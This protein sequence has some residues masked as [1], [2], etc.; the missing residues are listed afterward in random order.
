MSN[1][2][3]ADTRFVGQGQPDSITVNVHEEPLAALRY[4]E[5]P[6]NM[7]MKIDYVARTDSNPVYIGYVGRGIAEDAG[8]WILQ[9]FTYD[10]SDRMTVRQIAYDTWA[11]RASAT[12]A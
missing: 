10:T 11:N 1:N 9:K 5:I 7:Q 12:Y 8:E 3:N 2:I 6:S 4:T